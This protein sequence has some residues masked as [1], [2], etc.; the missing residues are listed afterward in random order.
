MKTKFVGTIIFIMAILSFTNVYAQRSGRLIWS[1]SSSAPLQKS[2]NMEVTGIAVDETGLYLIGKVTK[3]SDPYLFYYYSVLEKRNLKDGSLIYSKTLYSEAKEERL[4]DITIKDGYIYLS[5]SSEDLGFM[6]YS[7]R[8]TLEK[9]NAKN[10][11]LIWR[12]ESQH[13]GEASALAVDDSSIYVVGSEV[14]PETESVWRLEKRAQSDGSL[15]WAVNSVSGNPKAIKISSSSIYIG[16]FDAK[17][18][19]NQEFSTY[20]RVEKRDINNGNLI[21]SQNALTT[22][23]SQI[24]A[25]DL[26]ESGLYIV[27]MISNSARG[28][29]TSWK[30]E[31]RRFSDG[32]L[33]WSVISNP[34]KPY[35]VVSRGG[36]GSGSYSVKYGGTDWAKDVRASGNYIYVVGY[37]EPKEES[38]RW[39]IEKRNKNNGSLVWS[40][41]SKVGGAQAIA[42]DSSGMYIGGSSETI[43]TTD[44]E[45]PYT[46]KYLFRIEKR[47]L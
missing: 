2:G 9:R 12:Q 17:Y 13:F 26:D 11:D 36:K 18:V 35:T 1:V 15:I 22:E 40:I 29:D 25:I 33:I 41:S 21:W 19:P 38:Y 14:K 30:I 46:T 45:V 8:W 32:S 23:F 34:T 39:R 16:G 4:T 7:K 27:G 37:E 20:W 44:G 31:K 6:R 3:Y 47:S 5:G 42:I 28:D 24:E 43:V 10:G